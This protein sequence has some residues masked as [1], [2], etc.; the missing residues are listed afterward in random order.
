MKLWRRLKLL[1]NNFE[2]SGTFRQ[3]WEFLRAAGQHLISS[4]QPLGQILDGWAASLLAVGIMDASYLALGSFWTGDGAVPEI[5]TAG[6]MQVGGGINL[7]NAVHYLEE[8]A[9]HVIVTSHVFRDGKV[10]LERLKE[11]VH[12]VGKDMLVL[13]LSC[14]KKYA[15]CFM[16]LNYFF[17]ETNLPN[18][19]NHCRPSPFSLFKLPPTSLFLSNRIIFHYTSPTIV[20]CSHMADPDHDHGLVMDEQGRVIILESPFFELHFGNEDNVGDYVNRITYLLAL[21]LEA[22]IRPNPW[23]IVGHPPPPPP[24]ATFP[25]AKIVGTIFFVVISI[26]VWNIFSKPSLV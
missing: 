11:L 8:G 9:S 5:W 6:G 13:D 2:T 17:G 3:Q 16:Y 18:N 10:V 7:E 25:W 1:D 12:I 19:S 15:V 20:R 24:P 14:R 26:L 4:G 21:S 22:Y 23:I